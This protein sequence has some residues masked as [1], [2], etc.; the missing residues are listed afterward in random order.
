M[1]HTS[2]IRFVLFLAVLLFITGCGKKEEEK[3]EERKTPAATIGSAEELSLSTEDS[4]HYQFQYHQQSFQAVF[5]GGVWKIYDSY[6]IA[7]TQ[8]QVII[9]RALSDEHPVK[10][11][12][13]TGYRTADDLS[14]EWQQH[15]I[16]Y[17][18]LPDD[19]PWKK[20]AKDVDLNPEDQGKTLF[21]F[22]LERG[23]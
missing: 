7:N 10:D 9:C 4:V 18:L 19:S 21:Q 15:N 11:K 6:R 14:F 22:M 20:N 2:K 8:D 17:Y 5:E 23:F 1:P 13:G 3:K 12:A 16:A